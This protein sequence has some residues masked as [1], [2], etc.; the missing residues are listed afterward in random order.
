MMNH[1]K[2]GNCKGC[3]FEIGDSAVVVFRAT[4]DIQAGEEL[5]FNYSDIRRKVT[6]VNK[7]LRKK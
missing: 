1:S 4:I 6:E 7:F 3:A 5:L 2:R